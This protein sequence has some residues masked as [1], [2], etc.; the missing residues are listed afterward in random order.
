MTHPLLFQ[1]LLSHKCYRGIENSFAKH[2]KSFCLQYKCCC[3][4]SQRCCVK[5]NRTSNVKVQYTSLTVFLGRQATLTINCYS[6]INIDSTRHF[7]NRTNR[8]FGLQGASS[9]TIVCQDECD[10]FYIGIVVIVHLNVSQLTLK[11]FLCLSIY[12]QYCKHY[13]CKHQ[14]KSFHCVKI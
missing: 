12:A 9:I 1:I 13:Y 10:T 3:V 11:S 14:N 5:S 2:G 8:L 7:A 4:T 6:H